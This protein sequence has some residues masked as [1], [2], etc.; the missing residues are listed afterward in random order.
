MF[1][2]PQCLQIQIGLTQSVFFTFP[3]APTV[4]CMSVLLKILLEKCHLVLV[5]CKKTGTDSD[6]E[7]PVGIIKL[8]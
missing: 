6:S 5:I 2:L 1:W 8:G 3:H 7:I 4:V